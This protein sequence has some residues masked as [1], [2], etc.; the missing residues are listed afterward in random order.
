MSRGENSISS[1][2][3]YALQ[4]PLIEQLIEWR[5][6]DNG[7]DSGTLTV[8]SILLSNDGK[9]VKITDANSDEVANIISYGNILLSI[10]DHSTLHDKRLINIAQQ[11]ADGDVG[12]LETLH[13]MLERMVSST[14][15]KLL[16]AII[17]ISLMMVRPS[18]VFPQPDSPTSPSVSPLKMSSVTPSTAFTV[19]WF[20]NP[21]F[22]TV[23]CFFRSFISRSLVCS[24]II[25]VFCT[26]SYGDFS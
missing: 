17:I 5:D 26:E 2:D 18:V 11:C 24:A 13:L 10:I 21:D 12:N 3:L 22:F 7:D 15:Y 14:I 23:K 19:W 1:R 6:N 16:L 8:D 20:L 25:L 4:Q 9:H